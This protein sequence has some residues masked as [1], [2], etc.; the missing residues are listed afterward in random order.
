[1]SAL[2]NTDAPSVGYLWPKIGCVN[3]DRLKQ[4]WGD[5]FHGTAQPLFR[6]AGDSSGGPHVRVFVDEVGYQARVAPDKASLYTG[7]ENVPPVDDATQ[8]RYYAQLIAMTACDPDVALLNFFHAVDET[9]LAAWQSGMVL[10]DGTHRA[11]FSQVSAASR[12]GRKERLI[13]GRSAAHGTFRDGTRPRTNY[14]LVSY[15]GARRVALGSIFGG[16]ER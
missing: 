4:A 8:G 9:S 16:R 1:M 7:A 14:S 10:P 11:S 15:D 13:S 12:P 5:A 3:L 6:E 2:L